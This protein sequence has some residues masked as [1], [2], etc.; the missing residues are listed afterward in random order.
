[1]LLWNG[2][3]ITHFTYFLYRLSA[4]ATQKMFYKFSSA[5]SATLVRHYTIT[6][7]DT[8]IIAFSR[9]QVDLVVHHKFYFYSKHI[10]DNLIDMLFYT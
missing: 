8:W 10:L 9:M 2:F 5:T 1:M 3:P 4:L 6:V 7:Y